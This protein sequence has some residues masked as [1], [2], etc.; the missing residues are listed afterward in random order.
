MLF[1]ASN[2]LIYSFKVASIAAKKKKLRDV[3]LMDLLQDSTPEALNA[4]VPD[5]LQD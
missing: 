2:S 3:T 1:I 5:F 4:F